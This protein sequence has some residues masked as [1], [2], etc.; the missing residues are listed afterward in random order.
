M[1]INKVKQALMS[2]VISLGRDSIMVS[3]SVGQMSMLSTCHTS[4][5]DHGDWYYHM[6]VIMH[7]K[8]P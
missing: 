6:C 8:D 5:T 1:Y 3:I 2:D 7:V 4:A